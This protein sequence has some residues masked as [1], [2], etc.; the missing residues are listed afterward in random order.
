MCVRNLRKS[1][2]FFLR[3]GVAT[4]VRHGITHKG[5]EPTAFTLFTLSRSVSTLAPERDRSKANRHALVPIHQF[6]KKEKHAQN[7]FLLSRFLVISGDVADWNKADDNRPILCV[8]GS[9]PL[10][11]SG[12]RER[13]Y[14]K[15]CHQLYHLLRRVGLQRSNEAFVCASVSRVKIFVR[16]GNVERMGH[17]AR[18]TVRG[19]F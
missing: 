7:G 5:A 6:R 16:R 10:F 2:F 17:L 19:Y 11:F 3:R 18:E 14:P 4:S 15:I 9:S 12:N 1:I 8:R 13:I